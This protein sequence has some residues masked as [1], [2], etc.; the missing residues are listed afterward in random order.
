MKRLTKIFPHLYAQRRSQAAN[1]MLTPLRRSLGGPNSKNRPL[2]SFPV[3][4][5]AASLTLSGLA[6]SQYQQQKELSALCRADAFKYS[7]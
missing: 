4:A 7:V 2:D 6:Y 5:T 1:R 3:A